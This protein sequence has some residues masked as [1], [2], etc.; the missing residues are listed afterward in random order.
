MTVLRFEIPEKHRQVMM[1]KETAAGLPVRWRGLYGGRDG[2]KSHTAAKCALARGVAKPE[3]I[4]CVREVQQSL[5][6][7]VHAL[8]K[9]QVEFLGL[10]SFYTVKDSYI[11]GRNGTLFTFHGLSKAS[12]DSIK[13]LEGATI[14]WIE[15][16][17]RLSSRSLGILEPTIR[18]P[19][20][21]IWAIW[22]PEMETD[23]IH[24]K[25]AIDP[26]PD[27]VVA[28]VN[29]V[30]NPWQSRVLDV[31]REKMQRDDPDEFQHVY[32]GGT[33]PA[34]KGAIYY[35]EVSS[36]R[37][38]GRLCRVPYDPML[39]VHV[40]VDLG[41]ADLMALLL[42]QRMMSEIRIV[43]YIEDRYRDIPHYSQQLKALGWNWGKVY[44]P[45]DAK[46]TTLASANN[47]HGSTPQRQFEQL[48][49]RTEVLPRIDV[50][51]GIRKAREVFP[52][53]AMHNPGPQQKASEGAG[54]PAELLNRLGRYKRRVDQEGQAHD[55]VHNDDSNGADGFRYL[56][57]CADQMSNDDDR[58]DIKFEYE[59]ATA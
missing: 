18:A 5:D 20:S 46:S 48:G 36:L 57:L 27:A 17:N 1:A 28:H 8:L 34:V 32:L 11:E 12:R 25:L 4:P 2:A 52:R 40:V 56:A 22:N 23:P 38:S 51:Q 41:R 29:Y 15:E 33:R 37:A 54:N 59:Q 49:W 44:L 21:E 47:P 42:V 16:A 50:D 55:P 9:S 26:P 53:V 24:A 6:D 45:H 13:S 35:L 58:A 31:A 19:G 3:R 30:D 43:G 14:C 39:K 7:S 10:Q